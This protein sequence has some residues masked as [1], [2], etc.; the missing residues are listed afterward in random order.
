MIS[1]NKMVVFNYSASYTKSKKGRSLSKGIAGWE[2]G[3]HD[4]FGMKAEKL[5]NLMNAY[6]IAA[7]NINY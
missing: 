1:L 4:T 6:W 3:L 7:R 5:M 2:G